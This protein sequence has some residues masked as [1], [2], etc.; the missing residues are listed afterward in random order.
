M[1]WSYGGLGSRCDGNFLG[2]Y[3]Q[4]LPKFILLL[5]SSR[6]SVWTLSLWETKTRCK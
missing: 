4:A 3:K 1:F 2:E 5:I 6:T